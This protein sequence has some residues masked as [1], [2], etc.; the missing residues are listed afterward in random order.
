[1]SYAE[2]W[3][4]DP[5]LARA[6]HKA[7]ILR[8]Q[9]RSDNM[10]LQGQYFFEAMSTAL[11]NFSAGL[12]GKHKHNDYRKSPYRVIPKTE[13]EIEAEKKAEVEAR[14]EQLKSWQKAF[15]AKNAKKESANNG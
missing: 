2:Y 7:E 10:W 5:L 9:Q 15:E 13:K 12:A 3:E 6:Y 14:I 1:M 4:G 8:T 11:S